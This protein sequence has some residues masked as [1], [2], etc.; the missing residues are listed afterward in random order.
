MEI[1]LNK[2]WFLIGETWTI[3]QLQAIF[4]AKGAFLWGINK[5]PGPAKD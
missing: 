2:I 1:F 4:R 3:F 5:N